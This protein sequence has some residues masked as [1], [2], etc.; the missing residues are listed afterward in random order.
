M[1]IVV[2]AWGKWE[3]AWGAWWG[4]E[5]IPFILFIAQYFLLA[6]QLDQVVCTI[7]NASRVKQYSLIL[8]RFVH[9]KTVGNFCIVQYVCNM[10][11]E[12]WPRLHEVICTLYP[13]TELHVYVQSVY[14]PYQ[15]V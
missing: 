5:M 2:A 7:P 3:L 15:P 6:P 14:I 9:L 1:G 4:K 10:E 8:V 12:L 11:L 13:N